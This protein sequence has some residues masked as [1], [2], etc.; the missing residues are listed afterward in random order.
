MEDATDLD[1][2]FRRQRRLSPREREIMQ[3]MT[4]GM[5]TK[6]IARVLNISPRTVDIHRSRI[7]HKMGTNRLAALVRMAVKI[8]SNS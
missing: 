6:E 2:L 4:K 5:A 7:L 3:L 1:E 8:E